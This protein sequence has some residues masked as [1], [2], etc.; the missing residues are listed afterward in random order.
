M[1]RILTDLQVSEPLRIHENQS[2]LQIVA[3][4]KEWPRFTI[5]LST[6]CFNFI[7]IDIKETSTA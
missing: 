3:S 5:N 7:T 1:A 2:Q 4:S 6:V